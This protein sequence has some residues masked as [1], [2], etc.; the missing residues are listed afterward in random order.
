MTRLKERQLS[1]NKLFDL[2]Y[3]YICTVY[4]SVYT[5]VESAILEHC[6]HT[7]HAHHHSQD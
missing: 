7:E 2:Q 5:Q 1:R 3:R 6:I 4:C